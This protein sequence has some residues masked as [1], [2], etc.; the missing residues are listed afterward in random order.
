MNFPACPDHGRTVLDLARGRLDDVR[1][2]EA[3]QV[4]ESCPL[5]R[6]WWRENLEGTAADLV[7][8]AVEQSFAAFQPPRRRRIAV[9]MP[10]AAAVLLMVGAGLLWNSGE[11]DPVSADQFIGNGELVRESF[12][13]DTDGDGVVG[14]SD[15]GFVLGADELHADQPIFDDS[16]D[17]GDLSNWSSRT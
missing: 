12:D 11:P 14:I 16:V 9:W 13:G 15:L 4:L 2:V 6:A 3:E 7:D 1:A 17:S 8:E 5:C 10:A